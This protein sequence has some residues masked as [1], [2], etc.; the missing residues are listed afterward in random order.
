MNKIETIILLFC[1]SVF[2]Q[3]RME[4]TQPL[5]INPENFIKA[6]VETAMINFFQ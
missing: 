3:A 4:L 6:K 5:S 1:A 2:A